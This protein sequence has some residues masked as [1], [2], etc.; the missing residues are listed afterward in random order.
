MCNSHIGDPQGKNR[1]GGKKKSLLRRTN[2][3]ALLLWLAIQLV[4]PVYAQRPLQ[5][6]ATPKHP[7]TAEYYGAQAPLKLPGAPFLLASALLLLA[8]VIAARTLAT[9]ARVPLR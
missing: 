2:R 6:P 9:T 8:L 3:G 7:I 1:L 5:F 4:A